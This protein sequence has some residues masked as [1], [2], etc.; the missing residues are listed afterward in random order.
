[1]EK[2]KGEQKRREVISNVTVTL[3]EE[4]MDIAHPFCESA[5][6]NQPRSVEYLSATGSMTPHPIPD[7]TNSFTSLKKFILID[8]IYFSVLI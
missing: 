8:V 4:T 1:M 6:G 2:E 5:P 7:S 3:C